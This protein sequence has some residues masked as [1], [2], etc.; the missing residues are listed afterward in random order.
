MKIKSGIGYSKKSDSINAGSEAALS[1]MK[2]LSGEIPSLVLVFTS[3]KYDLP[4]LLET[5]RTIT[6]KALLIGSTSSGEI[7]GGTHL[8]IAEG[9]GVLALTAGSYK[10]GVASMSHIR[11]NLDFAGKTVARNAQKAVPHSPYAAVVLLADS[12]L[13]N[14]QELFQGVYRITGPRVAIVGG[15]AGDDQKFIHP[16]VFHNDEI[17]DEGVVALWIGSDHP[18]NVTT[19]HGWEPIG[20]PLLVTRAQ[21]TQIIE[22]SGCPANQVYEEQ[23]GLKPG[24]LS[25]QDFWNTSILHP[26]GMLQAD[27]SS[28]IR[29]ARS[30]TK[31]N[32]LNIQGCVPPV[33]SAVQVMAGNTDSLLGVVE[34]VVTTSLDFLQEPGLLLAFSCAAREMIFRDRQSEEAS[35]IQK[36]A[37]DIPTFG[38]Y[39]CGEFARTSGVLGTHNATLTAIAL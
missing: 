28:I 1:A 17:L 33:G 30:K 10:F 38:V 18:L 20:L 7:V 39:C 15:A 2:A 5:I 16:L 34:D 11:G 29:V 8:G 22:L 27:G 4:I 9:V 21:G 35:R 6:G 24:T 31:E 32:Y 37:G 3:P 14:L 19:R 23:L 12:M 26:L 13:G 25:D 36:A